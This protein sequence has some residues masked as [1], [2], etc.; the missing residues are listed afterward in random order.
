MK[1]SNEARVG[2][3]GIVTIAVL[4][5]GINYLKGRNIFSTDYTLYAFYPE[6]DGLEGSSPVL[7]NG[8]K[9]GYIEDI[10]L[11]T[12][13]SPPIRI[14]LK[15]DNQYTFG[16]GSLAKLIS[17]G[18]MGGKGIRIVASGKQV[19]MLDQDTIQGLVEP[20]LISSLQTALFPILEKT[21][22]LATSLDSLS[23]QMGILLSQDG[24]SQIIENLADLSYSLKSSLATGGSLNESFRNLESFTGI[25]EEEK[26][27]MASLIKN[28]NSISASLYRAGL[29]SLS[30][31]MSSTFSQLN[32]LMEQVNSG[33]GSAGKLLYSDSLYNNISVLVVDLD[34]LVKDLKENPKDYVQVSVFGKSKK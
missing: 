2:I 17:T 13:E 34:S 11:R 9:V 32:I 7:I 6:A 33:K 5:W 12:N 8:V 23:H 14:V 24:L 22:T 26:D 19:L 10:Q 28:L 25:L 16:E 1:I 29:D 30:M 3:I 27:E 18:L 4:I 21:N 20:D 31:E 15:I